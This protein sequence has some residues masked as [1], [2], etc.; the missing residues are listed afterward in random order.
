MEERKCFGC[1]GF[2]HVAKNCKNIG[3]ERL[4]QI[5]LN[6]FEVLRDRVIERGERS[7]KVMIDRREILREERA[8]RRVEV[9]KMKVERKEKKKKMLR[10][11][12]VKIGLKQE[13]ENK[14]IIMEVLLDS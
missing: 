8:K 14:G 12:V 4:V 2:G 9:Q 10:E 5:S 6:K 11:V 7:M 1:E 13:E 3:K